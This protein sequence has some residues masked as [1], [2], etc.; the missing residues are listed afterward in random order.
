MAYHMVWCNIQ[1]HSHMRTEIGGC[2]HLIAGNLCHH[3]A[4]LS[5]LQG[6]LTKRHTNIAAYTSIRISGFHQFSQQGNS[7]SFAI[8]TGNSKN[9]RFGQL[10]G[11]LYLANNRNLSFVGFL[12][13]RNPYWY[14]WRQNNHIHIVQQSVFLRPKNQFHTSGSHIS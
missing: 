3:A 4:V 6:L 5:S 11:H 13:Q 12:H 7:C 14:S 9:R 2:L 10:I 1:N 8:S